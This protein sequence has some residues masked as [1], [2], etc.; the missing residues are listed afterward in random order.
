MSQLNVPPV[1]CKLKRKL[2]TNVR[3]NSHVRNNFQF[4][5]AHHN[6]NL[7]PHGL[8]QHN[9]PRPNEPQNDIGGEGEQDEFN[10]MSDGSDHSNDSGSSRNSALMR[11]L[12]ANDDVEGDMVDDDGE[13]LDGREEPVDED[14]INIEDLMAQ[15][16]IDDDF[17]VTRLINGDEETSLPTRELVFP[18]VVIMVSYSPLLD[19]LSFNSLFCSLVVI[20]GGKN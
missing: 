18:R 10:Y 13:H 9:L 2:N 15:N 5:N 8:P 4:V 11:A 6:R 20:I 1:G 19:I 7:F 14:D 3:N 12:L 17:Y 16:S